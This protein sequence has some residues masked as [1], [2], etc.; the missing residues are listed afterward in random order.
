VNSDC[1]FT[2]SFS[3]G[4]TAAGVIVDGGREVDFI[5]TFPEALGFTGVAK[6]VKDSA[7]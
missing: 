7:D 4:S 3:D 1:S 5:E 2:N 6:R